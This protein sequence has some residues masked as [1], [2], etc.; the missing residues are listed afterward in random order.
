MKAI[1]FI[2]RRDVDGIN[3]NGVTV[4]KRGLKPIYRSCCWDIPAADAEMLVGDW[5]YLHPK[6]SAPSE[7]G[8]RVIRFEAGQEWQGKAHENRIAFFLEATPLGKGKP[9]R[10]AE[11]SLAWTGGLIE[12]SLPH[13]LT[14]A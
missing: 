14:P 5:V 9:W 6:K 12:A 11:H 2:C 13:E 1:H 8:G 7:F 10:G 3:L 4:V